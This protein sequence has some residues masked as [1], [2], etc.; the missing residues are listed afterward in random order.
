[1][2]AQE[3]SKFDSVMQEFGADDFASLKLTRN[4]KREDYTWVLV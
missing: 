4:M 3:R 1:M 2:N